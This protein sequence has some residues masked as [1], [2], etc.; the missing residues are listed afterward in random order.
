M[1]R[2]EKLKRLKEEKGEDADIEEEINEEPLKY[3][4]EYY[5]YKLTG[6]VVHSGTAD[7]G[8]YYSFIQDR[9]HPENGRWLELNDHI[10]REFDP[11]DIPQECF[12]GEDTF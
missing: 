1:R 12:G 11:A 9:E 7:S 5:E 6:I 4:K 2:Q 8:H 3:P 10:V